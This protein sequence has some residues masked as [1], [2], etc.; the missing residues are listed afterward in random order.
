MVISAYRHCRPGVI[1][2]PTKG[3]ASERIVERVDRICAECDQSQIGLNLSLDG[4]GEEHD[5]IRGI[6]GNWNRALA[7]WKGLKDVQA[8]RRN[9]EL[10][11]HTVV[12][13]F[14]QDRFGEIYAAPQKLEPDSYI[15]E[16]AEERVELCT[17]GWGITPEP[18]LEI[19]A[20]PDRGVLRDR[21][22]L[23]RWGWSDRASGRMHMPIE[24]AME[25]V[26]EQARRAG[27]SL[28]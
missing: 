25:R 11:V 7:T 14:N 18:D 10:S 24:Q 5:S 6:P 17:I 28:P 9:L 23:D 16:V 4:V 1:T 2:I 22:D 21:A 20:T 27:G 19:T 26:L 12:S 13:R 15:T 8:R 3:L